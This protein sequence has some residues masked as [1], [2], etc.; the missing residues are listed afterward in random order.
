MAKK[1]KAFFDL[2]Y[3]ISLILVIIPITNLVCGVIKRIQDGCIVAAIIRL[4]FG[5]NI[6]W[7]LDIIWM[8]LNKD[9]FCVL[10]F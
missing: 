8:L 4:F 1:Q 3:I 9:I 6:L 2:D 5:W 10:N 7:I